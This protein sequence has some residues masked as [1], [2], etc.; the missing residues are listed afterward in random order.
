MTDQPNRPIVDDGPI[1]SRT[2]SRPTSESGAVAEEPLDVSIIVPAYNEHLAID[3]ELDDIMAAMADTGYRFEVLVVDDGSTDGTGEAAGT[4]E[5]VT[6][7][8][9]P[10]NRGVGAARTTG[11]RRAR[12]RLVAF[13]DADR[14]YPV[15][16]LPEM[17]AMVDDGAD[18]VIGA[19][20]VEAGTLRWLRMPAKWAIKRLAEFM[21]GSHIPDL[22]S[23]LRVQR[24][25]ATLRDQAPES[26]LRDEGF[27]DQ[28]ALAG[29]RHAGH[30]RQHAYGDVDV[31]IV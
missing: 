20:R 21:T 23:G 4:R 8:S 2:D 16:R 19:R 25:D 11:V 28:R 24:R 26:R 17:L 1:R 18:M 22:N 7:I 15:D 14:T 12:G 3:A 9:H 5:G 30:Q 29:P 10:Y 27:V 13:T 31:Y 6:L